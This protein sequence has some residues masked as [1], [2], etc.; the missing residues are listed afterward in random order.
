MSLQKRLSIAIAFVLLVILIFFVISSLGFWDV[1]GFVRN[2][3]PKNVAVAQTYERIADAWTDDDEAVS[4]LDNDY[5]PK[6]IQDVATGAKIKKYIDILYKYN[7]EGKRRVKLAQIKSLSEEFFSRVRE[8]KITLAKRNSIFQKKV[9]A[10][11]AA[12]RKLSDDVTH[13]LTKFHGMVN[14]FK[15]T[16][17]SKEFRSSL[18]KTSDLVEKIIR[19]QNDLDLTEAEVSLYLSIR[20]TKDRLVIPTT[21]AAR[22]TSTRIRKRLDALTYLLEKSLGDCSTPIHTRV[23]TQIK[24]KINIFYESF[25]KLLHILNAPEGQMVEIDEDISKQKKNILKLKNEGVILSKLEAEIYWK[26]IFSTSEYINQHFSRNFLFSALFMIFA[27]LAALY[28]LKKFP[29]KIGGPIKVLNEEIK[30]FIF[31]NE[32][33]KLPETDF[34]EI[35]ELSLAFKD[36]AKRLQEQALLTKKY[37][38][39]IHQMAHVLK[40]LHKSGR[41]FGSPNMGLEKA[42]NS[43]LQNLIEICPNIDLIKVMSLQDRNFVRIGDPHFSDSFKDSSECKEYCKSVGWDMEGYKAI[44]E[45]K[46]PVEKGLTGWYYDLGSGIGQGNDNDS[47]FAP[48]HELNPIV[49]NKILVSREYEKGL[50]GCVFTERLTTTNYYQY[51]EIEDES[52]GLLFAYF[53]DYNTV[54]SWQEVYFLKIGASQISLMIETD[55]LLVQRDKQKRNEEQ[56]NMAKEIQENLLPQEIPSIENLEI[57]KISK[58]AAEVGGD[59]YDFFT[60]GDNKIG[61]VVADASGKNVPAAI[62]MTVFKTALST[63]DLSGMSAASVLTKANNIIAKNITSDRFITAMYIIIDSKTG[64]VELSSAGHNPAIVASG[65]ENIHIEEIN[66]K[67]VPLGILENYDFTSVK[68][69]LKEGDRLLLYTDGVT[70]ARNKDGKEFGIKRLKKFMAKPSF[71]EENDKKESKKPMA[72]PEPTSGLCDL[73]IKKVQKFSLNTEQHDDITAVGI[74]FKGDNS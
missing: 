32:I 53:H 71:E 33:N 45:E 40:S 21:K 66:A 68:F 25:R 49:D 63:M 35:N 6:V 2:V 48:K 28:A 29:A 60:L 46:I 18:I 37:T 55:E 34:I 30:K 61:I 5:N 9:N 42:I 39:F 50:E 12:A 47:F 31:G 62:I 36:M 52:K 19:I 20:F 23:L 7:I 70:E 16:L 10:Q 38:E 1:N 69:T 44:K 4:E 13:L 57:S 11:R 3:L 26:K 72:K 22:E 58:S 74:V 14:D 43:V 27:F 64:V 51:D 17:N 15:K 54:L 65:I 24:K 67:G 8:L 41:S 56:L 73:L 59:Y